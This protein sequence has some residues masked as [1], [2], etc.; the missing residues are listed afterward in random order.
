MVPLIDSLLRPNEYF[1]RNT[2]GL[3]L[4][5]AGTVALLIAVVSTASLG[6]FGYALA[7]RADATGATVTVDNE[8]RPPD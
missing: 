1:D 5:R 8:H 3:S 7:E 2:P 6:A 4:A